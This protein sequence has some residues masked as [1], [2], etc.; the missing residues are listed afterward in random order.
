MDAITLRNTL[1]VIGAIIMG[2]EQGLRSAPDFRSRLPRAVASEYWN[3]A[4]LILM[5]VAGVIWVVR[6]VATPK[7]ELT[8]VMSSASVLT[9]P[10]LLGFSQEFQQALHHD[11]LRIPRPCVFKV[12]APQDDEG[13]RSQLV[14]AIMNAQVQFLN[15]PNEMLIATCQIVDEEKDRNVLLYGPHEFPSSG[16]TIHTSQGNIE[17]REFLA[18]VFRSQSIEVTGDSQLPADSPAN[19]IYIEFGHRLYR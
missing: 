4:P 15:R 8:A 12:V 5:T 13:P 2:I 7:P 19:L 17:T 1:F 3:F 16:I 18:E 6:T 10:P 11:F 14:S 9:T